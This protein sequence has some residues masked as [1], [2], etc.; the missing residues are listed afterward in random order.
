MTSAANLHTLDAPTLA[1]LQQWVGK[2]ETLHDTV[3][4]QSARLWRS[5]PSAMATATGWL[6]APCAASV[7]SDTPSISCLA[8]LE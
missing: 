3:T 8:A 4:A 6:T 1:H 5:A 7:A 2:S